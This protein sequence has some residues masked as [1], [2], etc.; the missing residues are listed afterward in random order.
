MKQT[1]KCAVRFTWL[2]KPF[3]HY[4]Q[5]CIR[6]IFSDASERYSLIRSWATFPDT[7]TERCTSWQCI[8]FS[9]KSSPVLL[10]LIENRLMF[11]YSLH[12]ITFRVKIFLENS[13]MSSNGISKNILSQPASIW[14]KPVCKKSYHLGCLTWKFNFLL[15]D[16]PVL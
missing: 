7:D 4:Q 2:A 13:L 8:F 11:L 12:Q 15:Q 16:Y 3:L 14:R 5:I 9:R 1:Q 6:Q 10:T